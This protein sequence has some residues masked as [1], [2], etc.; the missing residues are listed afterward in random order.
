M[1]SSLLLTV[2]SV[3]SHAASVLGRKADK[4]AA[5]YGPGAVLVEPDG[6]RTA[7]T[8]PAALYGRAL[9]LGE[10]GAKV[11]RYKG[12]GEM[13]AEQLW[14]TTLDPARRTLLKVRVEDAAKADELFSV[15]MGDDVAERKN[16]VVERAERADIDA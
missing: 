8:G 10:H 7:V 5:T 3:S 16:F 6:T 9:S 15:L 13:N 2:E 12:L 11:S 4:L 1:T 14:E